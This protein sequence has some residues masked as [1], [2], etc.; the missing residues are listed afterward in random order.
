METLEPYLEVALMRKNKLFFHNLYQ[1]HF[2]VANFS[3]R[4]PSVFQY[5]KVDPILAQK[6]L[7]PVWRNFI[8]F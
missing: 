2:Y 5:L 6:L 7:L 1:I 3:L 4:I 8:L